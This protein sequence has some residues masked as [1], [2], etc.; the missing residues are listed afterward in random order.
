M[1]NFPQ[2]QPLVKECHFGVSPVDNSDSDT[3]R[4]GESTSWP[5]PLRSALEEYGSDG[6]GSSSPKTI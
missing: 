6:S 3:V 4:V 1:T 5:N 2:S